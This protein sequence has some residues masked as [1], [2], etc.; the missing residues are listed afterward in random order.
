M[1]E[2]K[3]RGKC[4]HNAHGVCIKFVSD[5]QEIHHNTCCLRFARTWPFVR[6]SA[7][8]LVRNQTF[9]TLVNI[10]YFRVFG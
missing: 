6:P 8:A 7:H 9:A 4:V 1:L 5:R 10:R 3:K 2:Y